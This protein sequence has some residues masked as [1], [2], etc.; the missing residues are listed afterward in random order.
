VR[1]ASKAAFLGAKSATMASKPD[2][3]AFGWMPVPG[4]T[5]CSM[6]WCKELA[7]SMRWMRVRASD[8]RTF[9]DNKPN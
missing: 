5:S 3:K 8:M 6:N 9:Q 1:S 7:T 4:K 2:Q